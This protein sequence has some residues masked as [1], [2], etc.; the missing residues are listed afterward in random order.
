[1]IDRKSLPPAEVARHC[2]GMR[3]LIIQT[4]G[5]AGMG[6]IGGDLS[7][8][9]ILGSL[10]FH[11]LQYDPEQPHHPERDRFIMSKGHCAVALYT[12]MTS[13]GYFPIDEL[14]TFIQPRSRL[15]GHPCNVKLPGVETSTG[16]LG[17]GLPVGVGAAIGAKLQQKSWQVFVVVGD[18]ELQ[19]GSNW[20]AAMTAA[21]KQLD[22]LTLIIDRNRMQ[23]GDH[24]QDVTS[25]EPLAD[26]FTAFGW[27]THEVDGHD[28]AALI[29]ALTTPRTPGM[30]RCLVAHTIKGNGISFIRDRVEW[31][32]KVPTPEQIEQALAELESTP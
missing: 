2:H 30:P 24:T 5:T 3:K 15:N 29:N 32:H 9:D 7:V 20:E 18:G 28:H 21:Y 25:M 23:Q 8:T 31:H 27:E 10:Y 6:H 22:N 13:A 12:V 17:H 4:I 11:V 1:M 14:S 26:R 16:P 19:E